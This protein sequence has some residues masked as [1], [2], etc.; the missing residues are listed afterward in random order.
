ME[1]LF[2]PGGLI[3]AIALLLVA[4]AAVTSFITAA[5]GL[6]GGVAL[7]AVMA[8]VMPPAALIP[9]HG[10]V[11][12]GSNAGRAWLLRG[13]VR[14]GALTPFLLGAALGAAAGGLVAVD[15]PPAAV[16]LGVGLFILWSVAFRP[17]GWLARAGG[18]AGAASSFLTM[19]FGA[20]GPFV[21]AW[22]RTLHLGREAHSATH[23]AAMV[24]QHGLKLLA[25]G[26]LG[27][28]FGPW[29]PL[30][31]AM[32]LSGFAG[33]WAGRRLLMRLT[34]RVFDRVLAVILVLLALRLV[35]R[36]VTGL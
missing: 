9:V 6:G 17:P 27:F 14:W 35:W 3:P 1:V 36:G 32:L 25:F 18:V 24:A 20:T 11:Q 26:I 2:T 21:A 7:L 19:F 31:A 33:T 12:A 10:V 15:L 5:F 23:A 28:A 8:S 34:D 16:E 4:V 13:A 30:T 29:L 22:V